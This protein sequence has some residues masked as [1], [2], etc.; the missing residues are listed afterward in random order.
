MPI[1]AAPPVSV[2]VQWGK[3]ITGVE[4]HRGMDVLDEHLQGT[5]DTYHMYPTVHKEPTTVLSTLRS[6]I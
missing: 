3:G 4:N 1:A 2:S 6:I 5:A